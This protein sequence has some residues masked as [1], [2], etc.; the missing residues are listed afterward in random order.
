MHPPP[1]SGKGGTWATP[2]KR[3][4]LEVPLE[5]IPFIQKDIIDRAKAAGKP[6]IATGYS[7]NLAFMD[8][9]NSL[10]VPYEDASGAGWVLEFAEN[11]AGA[12]VLPS[13]ETVVR[14]C[15]VMSHQIRRD[16]SPHLV[17]R[18]A[19]AQ[20]ARKEALVGDLGRG[21]RAVDVVDEH[22]NRRLDAGIVGAVAEAADEEIGVL[23][24]LPLANAWSR[25]RP[26]R[27]RETSTR[28]NRGGSPAGP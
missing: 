2:V 1:L 27:S 10:L 14:L 24:A 22:A 25:F 16:A 5:E 20:V 18:A 8:E 4:P 28:S 3:D 17:G 7:G 11:A 26:V 9:E 12:G 13:L 21:A 15:P 23:R 19:Q 6:V